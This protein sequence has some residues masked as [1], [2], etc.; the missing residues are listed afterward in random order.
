MKH[1]GDPVCSDGINFAS[2]A[3]R[4]QAAENLRKMTGFPQ[5]FVVTSPLLQK[6]M[7]KLLKS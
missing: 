3:T 7:G 6:L 5:R 4:Q 2:G 1:S